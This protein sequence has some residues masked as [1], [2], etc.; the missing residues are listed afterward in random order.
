[1]H[2]DSTSHADI[3]SWSSSDMVSSIRSRRFLRFLPIFA[4]SKGGQLVLSQAGCCLSLLGLGKRSCNWGGTLEAV[5]QVDFPMGNPA[6]SKTLMVSLVAS[7]RTTAWWT[8][9]IR[10]FQPDSW[11]MSE[12]DRKWVQELAESPKMLQKNLLGSAW[13]F[14]YPPFLV[15]WFSD[16]QRHSWR[17]ENFP[18]SC[19]SW[20]DPAAPRC[21]SASCWSHSWGSRDWAAKPT[22]SW[23]VPGVFALW[24]SHFSYRK[25]P[26]LFIGT[27]LE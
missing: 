15:M 11:E 12:K 25:S 23:D 5:S 19:G 8:W 4:P 7:D 16:V 18:T 24:Y 6:K 10:S 1:M 21:F 3:F 22:K 27:S 13:L 14:G 9:I 2:Y 17:A 26:L 20:V